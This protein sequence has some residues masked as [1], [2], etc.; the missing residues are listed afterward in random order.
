M[1]VQESERH[2][3]LVDT[4]LDPSR[5]LLDLVDVRGEREGG[6]IEA[7]VSVDLIYREDVAVNEA[8][9][10]ELEDSIVLESKDE[11]TGQLS[12]I[13]LAQVPGSD[14]FYI[15]D[16]FHRDAALHNLGRQEVFA[17]IR[18][19]TT[20]E[21]L[22]DLR[23]LTA[24][25]HSAVSFARTIE[26]IND[27]WSR[28]PWSS[29]ITPTQAFNLVLNN[30][31]GRNLGLTFDQGDGIKDW[32]RDK[33][34]KW[35]MSAAG[36]RANLVTA[37]NADP[38]L[39]QEARGR[40]GGRELKAIT[41]AQLKIISE[42]FPG[43]Y[44]KQQ[45]V[46]TVS[47]LHNYTV[48]HTR[49]A[50]ELIAR[51]ETAEEAND[52]V[53][54]TNW[55]QLAPLRSSKRQRELEQKDLAA[56]VI[57]QAADDVLSLRARQEFLMAELELG[58]LSLQKVV[59]LGN[60]TAA[61]EAN[62]TTGGRVVVDVG[63]N[64]DVAGLVKGYDPEPRIASFLERIDAVQGAMGES[65]ARQTHLSKRD[66][67]TLI[68]IVASRITHDMEHGGLKYVPDVPHHMYD[69]LMANGVRAELAHNRMIDNAIRSRN[70]RKLEPIT[71]DLDTVLET[72]T[73]LNPELRR[74][75]TLE[76]FMRLNAFAISQVL[77]EDSEIISRR[78]VKLR[79]RYLAVGIDRDITATDEAAG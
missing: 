9:V 25:M 49:A 79:A 40:S 35:N 74:Q 17:T 21:E 32:V 71:V 11:S 70:G 75:L 24:N 63:R 47:K 77:A 38:E 52:I 46:A 43:D 58:S 59:L 34:K 29:Q 23:I 4:D 68:N 56:E 30:S 44:A 53:D 66:A 48:N 12:P 41:P 78:S 20:V 57:R 76:G 36:I 22:L 64:V 3:H 69:K 67:N 73:G 16:G 14:K 42:A 8:H 26:W 72:Y 13:L 65:I 39:V 10:K 7:M 19:N 61:D 45:V 60:Y 54:A 6:L 37:E 1:V 15:V 18:P 51:A 5:A 28:T 2:L 62:R 55:A 50:V 31:S 27:A 33:S